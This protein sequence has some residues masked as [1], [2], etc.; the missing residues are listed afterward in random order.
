MEPSSCYDSTVG[1]FPA[2][3]ACR[4]GHGD[5]TDKLSLEE[6]KME[7]ASIIGVGA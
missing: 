3:P 6:I 4:H 1:G 7:A 2:C 5:Q